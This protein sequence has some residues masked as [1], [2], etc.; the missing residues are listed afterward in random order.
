MPSNDKKSHYGYVGIYN[1]HSVCYMIAM[2]QQFYMC[3]AFR[4]GILCANDYKSENLVEKDDKKIDDNLFH[5]FQ[6]MFAYLDLS[7]RKDFNPSQFCFSFKDWDGNPVNVA[8]QQDSHE[9]LNRIFDKLEQGGSWIFF[10]WI[11]F[12]KKS[13]K[14]ICFLLKFLMKNLKNPN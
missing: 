4:Y 6:R 2:L 12:F 14:N 5:Q 8:I 1:M 10:S 7:E 11:F 9:F 3:P 13:F